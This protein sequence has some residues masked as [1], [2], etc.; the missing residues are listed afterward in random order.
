MKHLK[1]FLLVAVLTTK[2]WASTPPPDEG[3]WL[4]MLI[5]Q[6]IE[7]MRALGLK[8]TAEQIYSVNNGSL[9]DAIPQFSGYCTSEIISPDGLLLTNHHCGYQHI[10]GRSTTEH[11]YLRDGFW[12][13]NRQQE[14][15]CPDLKVKFLVR[16]D[17]VT[18]RVLAEVA[19]DMTESE[20]T[21]K[22]RAAINQLQDE[23]SEGTDY[24][25]EIKDFF[26]GSEYYL[27][28]YEEYTD[29]RLVG[30]PP[31]N[32]GKFGGDTDNW[33][34]PR[35]TGDFSIFRIY[36][37]KDNK[38][39]A[40]STDNV[41]FKPKHFLPVN[42]GGIKSGDYAMI[43]GWP[44]STNRYMTGHD[45]QQQVDKINPIYI[46]LFGQKLEVMKG[47]MDNDPALKISYA[48]KYASEANSWKY[49]IG[50][51]QGVQ[52][53]HVADERK[54]EEA[55]FSQWVQADATRQAKYGDVIPT[56]NQNVDASLEDMR[57][58]MYMNVAL[59]A[60]QI[61][62]TTFQKGF[63]VY[64]ALD[65]G[66][67]KN[68]RKVDPAEVRAAADALLAELDE[69]YEHYHAPLDR[70]V[71]ATLYETFYRDIPK[72]RHPEIFKTI[73]TK[74]KGDFKAYANYVYSTSIFA[75]K[76]RLKAFLQKPSWALISNDPA[77]ILSKG[78][79]GAV[80]AEYG[81]YLKHN[82]ANEVP[83]RKYVQAL[84]EMQ[85]NKK[86]YPDA[87]LT[88]RVTYGTVK[89]Y[90]PA[91]AVHYDFAT[92]HQGILEKFKPED[93]EFDVPARLI[94]L[95]EKKDFG[96]WANPDGSLPVCFLT[97]TDI[98]GGNSG[99][100]VLDA[101]GNIIGCAFDGNW[102]AMSGDLVF[103]TTRKRTINVDIRYVLFIIEKLGNAGHLI[104]EMKLVR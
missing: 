29:I 100:P 48:S 90:D 39:A 47:Y 49:F 41:P 12:A 35:H 34:W 53:L 33:M 27:F 43:M 46:K 5:G 11:N 26:N 99:S 31:E 96:R 68:K 76:E 55:R 64:N 4:P 20:R 103:D 85:P 101:S 75:T 70:D 84:R 79:I 21:A 94:E 80:R 51:S 54:A 95:L 88:M 98:T 73:E 38:P 37:G 8:L 56:I 32:V 91:D 25:V 50:Q 92:T 59:F 44:G 30:T 42:V 78:M 15:H 57:V 62:L 24:I 87:N 16:M 93:L 67:G 71:M 81:N 86:F 23:A 22:I 3:M 72:E 7:E 10:A 66:T 63:P 60:P 2:G 74:Y 18:K 19:D 13:M 17:D 6:N 77:I 65:P 40:Y 14:I 61:V 58:F 45:I 9:K 83:Y 97:D 69:V 89:N 28:V 82:S 36:A 104:D 52:K 102:E 1:L